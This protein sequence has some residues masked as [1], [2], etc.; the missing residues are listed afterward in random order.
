MLNIH[1]IDNLIN[2]TDA[3]Y[4][5]SDFDFVYTFYMDLVHF[6]SS[7]LQTYSNVFLLILWIHG[8]HVSAYDEH[9]NLKVIIKLKPDI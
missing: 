7:P 4:E 6:I 1:L 2:Y 8:H 3:V 9:Q 5:V